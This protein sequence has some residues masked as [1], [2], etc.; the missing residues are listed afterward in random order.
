MNNP[1]QN[2]VK[3]L[4]LVRRY[5]DIADTVYERLVTPVVH[6]GDLEV[7]GNKYPAFRSQ[8]NNA[9]GPYKGG[10]RFHPNVTEDEVK[11]LSMWMTWKCAVV[12]IPYGGG[13]GGVIVNPS[14]LSQ[15]ELEE[16]SRAYVRLFADVIGENRD[17]PAPDVN[18]DGQIMAWM[19]DEYENI[20]GYQ[21]PG[22]FTGKPILLGGSLGREEATG[23]GGF[24]VLEQLAGKLGLERTKTRIAVQGLGNVGYWFAK[25]ASEAGYQI[26]A[27]ADSKAGVMSEKPLNIEE[28]MTHKKA[29]GSVSGMKGVKEVL[30][31][32]VL[33]Q[34]VEVVVPAALENAI[35]GENADRVKARAVIEMA[36]G[37]V[38]P[39]A[40]EV[41]AGKGIVFVPDILANAGG[42]S[43]S[44]FEWVQ[45]RQGYAWKKAEVFERLKEMMEGAFE[46]VWGGYELGKDAGHEPWNMRLAAY[47]VAVRRVVE[48]M[49]WRG[50]I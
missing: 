32:E 29:T 13:K 35:S 22:T 25:L 44:Y 45:N 43:V 19:L 34:D 24:Y 11:A 7:A 48:A 27:V 9:R 18:T 10:I 8:H 4:D 30:S 46:E 5:L 33:W 40:D 42:V 21:T 39:E 12:G 38:T 31:D 23:M 2:A 20:V 17:V 14:T 47:M 6:R 3:Q 49:G 15:E 26:V 41:L 50:G 36:N 28:V 37:P 16:L 1:W